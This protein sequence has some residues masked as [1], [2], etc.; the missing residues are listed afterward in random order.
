MQSFNQKFLII[1]K[2]IALNMLALLAALLISM[3]IHFV[4]VVFLNSIEEDNGQFNDTTEIFWASGACF[5]Y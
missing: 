3:V 1:R 4:E 5:L 2:N